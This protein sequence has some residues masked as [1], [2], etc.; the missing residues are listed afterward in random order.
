MR[1]D[2]LKVIPDHVKSEDIRLPH[3]FSTSDIEVET[4]VDKSI[5][6]EDAR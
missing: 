4:N 6:Y 5:I 2:Q 3:S 1:Y